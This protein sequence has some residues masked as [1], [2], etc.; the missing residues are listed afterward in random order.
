MLELHPLQRHDRTYEA[1][2]RLYEQVHGTLTDEREEIV[3]RHATYDGWAGYVAA[4]DETSVGYVY[5]H[6]SQPGQ[7]WH[8]LLVEQLSRRRHDQ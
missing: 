6:H 5:G 3:D 2:K 8:D 1:M 4:V 7:W